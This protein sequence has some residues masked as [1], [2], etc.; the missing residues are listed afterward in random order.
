MRIVIIGN[1]AT[2]VGAIESM[3][4]HDQGAEI[5]V[6][7]EEPHMI[8]S[9]PMLSH[10]LGGRDRPAAAGLSRPDFYTRHNVQ[11]V[12]RRPAS[13][14]IDTGTPHSWSPPPP[15]RQY[16]YDKLLICTGGA[17]HR[18]AHSRA[19]RAGGLHLYPAGRCPGIVVDDIKEHRPRARRGGGRRHDRH[20]GHR[21]AD[22]RGCAGHH[23]RAGAA[24]P[25]RRP[26]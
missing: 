14:R 15:G 24:H 2:A 20:Q 21:C 12:L 16:P 4:Q 18:A 25:Q 6:I 1:S 26:G 23:G 17:A 3:R 22:E 13:T 10:Y 19:G 8:Y 11:P 7:S 9:R 5:M